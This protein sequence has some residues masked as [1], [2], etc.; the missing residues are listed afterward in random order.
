MGALKDACAFAA[1]LY[2]KQRTQLIG[3]TH[4]ILPLSEHSHAC[5]QSPNHLSGSIRS[6]NVRSYGLNELLMR[7]RWSR[8]GDEYK[9]Y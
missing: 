4:E 3:V 6:T 8:Y 1:L 9:G 7:I 2:R 5:T